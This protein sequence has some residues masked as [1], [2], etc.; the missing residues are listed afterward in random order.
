MKN[1]FKKNQ[2]IITALAIMIAVAGY[3]SFTNRDNPGGVLNTVET[4]SDLKNHEE[5]SDLDEN[6]LFME[7]NDGE[8]EILD[9][10]ATA[11]KNGDDTSVSRKGVSKEAENNVAT[12]APKKEE[13]KSGATDGNEKNSVDTSKDASQNSE[14]ASA[15]DM[16]AGAR[17]VMDNGELKPEDGAPGEA[18]LASAT[19]DEGFF[20]S[21]KLD[22]E[23]IRAKNKATLKEI[24][25]SADIAAKE[26]KNAV[27]ILLKLTDIADKESAAEMSLGAKGFDSAV[28]RISDDRVEVVV[29]A[30]SLTQQQLAIIED[31][32]KNKTDIAVEKIEISPVIIAE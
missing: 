2:I 23:Q 15:E 5:F 17:E 3:L 19:Q 32:V 11:E 20:M 31:I 12:K 26:K 7:T 18:V 6:E 24:I 13:K 27:D 30:P 29:N 21:A 25:E 14:A 9:W 10:N 22:R 28:V 4:A 1:I 16:I 8:E